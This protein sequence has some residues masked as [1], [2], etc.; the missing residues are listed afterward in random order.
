MLSPP[1]AKCKFFNVMWGLRDR[2]ADLE[3]D[4]KEFRQLF[5][6]TLWCTPKIPRWGSLVLSQ[7]LKY[8][9]HQPAGP[10]PPLGLLPLADSGLGSLPLHVVYILSYFHMCHN[11][12]KV[13]ALPT[14]LYFF[15]ELHIITVKVSLG[16]YLN[17]SNIQRIALK[18]FR[19]FQKVTQF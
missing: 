14:W 5:Y 2:C 9:S 6:Q 10:L 8:W 11:V 3:G 18:N 19:P 1:W 15:S 16:M 7:V 4:W 13:E 12:K 17:N